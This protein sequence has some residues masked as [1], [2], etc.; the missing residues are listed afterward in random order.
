MISFKRKL[1]LR[2]L[3]IFLLYRNNISLGYLIIEDLRRPLNR[4]DLN[5]F[6]YMTEEDI[7][8]YQNIIKVDFLTDEELNKEDA[9]VF[10][11]FAN[12]LVDTKDFCATIFNYKVDKGIFLEMPTEE[13]IGFYQKMLILVNSQY[14]LSSVNL[15]DLVFLSQD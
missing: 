3:E 12:D 6:I 11:E 13:D 14:E 5:T 8:V 1:R 10:E 15:K 7:G 4:D 2:D 9:V